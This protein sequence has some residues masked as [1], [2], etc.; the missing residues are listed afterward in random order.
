MGAAATRVVQVLF[1][2]VAADDFSRLAPLEVVG[3]EERVNQND[4]V[5]E[6]RRDDVQKKSHKILETLEVVSWQPEANAERVNLVVFRS[7]TKYEGCLADAAHQATAESRLQWNAWTLG[8]GI[9]V[10]T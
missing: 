6:R 7:A 9:M 4:D 1:V 5:H 2:A 8:K 10:L 3:M